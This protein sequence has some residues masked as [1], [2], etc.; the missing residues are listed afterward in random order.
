MDEP[1]RFKAKFCLTYFDD[2]GNSHA[3]RPFSHTIQMATR[4][5]KDVDGVEMISME[6]SASRFTHEA[7]QLPLNHHTHGLCLSVISENHH[8]A[9]DGKLLWRRYLN[10]QDAREL[11]SSVAE[12]DSI[13]V[14]GD[15]VS[16]PH[17][18][19][20]PLTIGPAKAPRRGEY[21]TGTV[22]LEI[23]LAD[24]QAFIRRARN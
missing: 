9:L 7:Y 6:G 17:P 14:A 4:L 12:T 18:P 20:H 19:V 15:L 1:D 10:A 24:F 8:P 5:Y 23:S 11:F 13:R 16:M 3:S 21:M 2:D 22:H